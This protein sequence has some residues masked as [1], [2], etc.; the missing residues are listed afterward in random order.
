[1]IIKK[2]KN[3]KLL[4]HTVIKIPAGADGCPR[5]RICAR[6]TLRSAP[7]Q[8]QQKFFGARVWRGENLE[9]EVDPPNLIFCVT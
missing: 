5:S 3:S 7:H 1:M 4:F 6:L 9:T 8:H 2:G